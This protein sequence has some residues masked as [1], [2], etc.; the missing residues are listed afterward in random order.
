MLALLLFLIYINNLADLLPDFNINA[1]FADDVSILA[2]ATSKEEAV[3]KAQAAVDIVIAWSREWELNLNADKSEASFFT[4]AAHEAKFKP[5]II[6]DKKP[7]NVI[8]NPRL[9]GVFLDCKLS[10]NHHVKVVAKKTSSKMRML[11]AVSNSEWGWRKH[12]LKKLFIAHVRSV[13]DYAGMA[14]QPWLSKS[15][16]NNLDV[17][18]KKALRLITRQAKTAP[19]ESIRRESQVPSIKSVIE[20]T[21]ESAREK[22]LRQPADHPRRRF[23]DQAPINRLVSRTSCRTKGIE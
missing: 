17:C 3:R 23:L 22:A 7:I 8:Q 12:D 21:C 9:L 5:Q 2:S 15:Q 11:A 6:I 10:F 4:T 19:V 14:W 13:I 1:M 20:T 18:Q 16:V